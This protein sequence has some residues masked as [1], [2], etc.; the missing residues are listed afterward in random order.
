MKFS[1]I[2]IFIFWMQFDVVLKNLS[3]FMKMIYFYFNFLS[4]FDI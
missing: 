3:V 4:S 2:I 1:Y